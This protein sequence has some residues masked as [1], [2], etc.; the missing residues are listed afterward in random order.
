MPEE[1]IIKNKAEKI[2]NIPLPGKENFDLDKSQ[3]ST[4][5]F[6]ENNN[7]N[8]EQAVNLD[9]DIDKSSSGL[10]LPASVK[11]N[12]LSEQ[13][14]KIDDILEEDLDD[15]FLKMPQEKRAEFKKKGEEAVK[16][17]SKI[18]QESKVKIKKI[19]NI[20]KKWLSMI[21]GV[22]KFYLE[23]MTKNKVD[24]ILKLKRDG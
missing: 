3:E 5:S 2:S 21:P 4:E 11:T 19:I 14:E 13:E 16:E 6:D 23:Q 18:L 20:L 17:I 7:S 15:I 8:I 9:Q 1:Q 24:E 22:N 12:G 10:E